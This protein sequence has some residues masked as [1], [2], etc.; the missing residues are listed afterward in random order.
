MFLSG[1]S[2]A[3]AFPRVMRI[4]SLLVQ[5]KTKGQIQKNDGLY[6]GNAVV[7]RVHR[8]IGRILKHKTR[9]LP[10]YRPQRFF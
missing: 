1:C 4:I 5:E 2:V 9:W 3:Q 10:V 6:K 7:Q 8:L